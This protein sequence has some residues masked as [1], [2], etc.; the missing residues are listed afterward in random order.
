MERSDQ[1]ETPDEQ[2]RRLH[3]KR[4]GEP[5]EGFMDI[6]PLSRSEE[7]LFEKM[8]ELGRQLARVSKVRAKLLNC[9]EN[10]QQF[11]LECPGCG[12][13]NDFTVEGRQIYYFAHEAK[14]NRI[15][16]KSTT[17]RRIAILR[18][19]DDVIECRCGNCNTTFTAM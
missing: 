4:A 16:K 2:R 1:M 11:L 19:T 15:P 5:G 8:H 12:L 18:E 17:L 6:R 14:G 10:P 9:L 13:M 3:G 7:D